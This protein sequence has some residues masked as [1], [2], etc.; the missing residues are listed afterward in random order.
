MNET[1]DVS[2]RWKL[3][4]TRT[5]EPWWERRIAQL[6]EAGHFEQIESEGLYEIRR[7]AQTLARDTRVGAAA[8]KNDGKR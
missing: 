1:S 5:V 8:I 4:R 7:R 2:I 3:R 6:A